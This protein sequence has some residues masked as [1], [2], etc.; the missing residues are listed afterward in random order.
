MLGLVADV[1]GRHGCPGAQVRAGRGHVPERLDHLELAGRLPR[2]VEHAL[3]VA[4]PELAEGALEKDPRL[5]KSGRRLEQDGGARAA[6]GIAQLRCGDLL[7]VAKDGEGRPEPQLA[8]PL[9]PLEAQVQELGDAVQLG[10]EQALVGRGEADGLREPRVRLDKDQLALLAG[11]AQRGI[12]RQLH[13]VP[14]VVGPELRLAG[15]ERAGHRLYLPQD[16]R[17][18]DPDDLVDPAG[19]RDEPALPR[20][21]ALDRDLELGVGPLR[22]GLC[23]EFPVPPAT[24]LRP[25]EAALAAGGRSGSDREVREVADAHPGAAPV[26]VEVHGI[27][28]SVRDDR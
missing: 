20:D 4:L 23:L 14:G 19:E 5:A 12:G 18:P 9:P 16:G 3:E 6:D 28:I 22:D 17:S 25:P 8:Q 2:E 10:I 11:A 7:A 1:P 26:Q 24:E 15:G 27:A 13:E 21:F